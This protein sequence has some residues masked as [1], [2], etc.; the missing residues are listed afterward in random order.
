MF[1]VGTCEESLHTHT[2]TMSKS[3]L[4]QR[5]TLQIPRPSQKVRL[6]TAIL[7][8]GST[9]RTLTA[10]GHSAGFETTWC[11]WEVDH[12]SRLSFFR[13][14]GGNEEFKRL[15]GSMSLTKKPK[16]RVWKRFD[17]DKGR[18]GKW[19]FQANAVQEGKD[20]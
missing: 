9:K 3:V 5:L 6:V 19:K 13:T 4:C 20:W 18:W 11:P 7:P 15:R 1:G 17:L 8:S 14:A 2:S 10:L 16:E 12:Q